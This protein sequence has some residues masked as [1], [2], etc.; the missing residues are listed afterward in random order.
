[1]AFFLVPL[2]FSMN[3]E[4][5]I[6]DLNVITDPECNKLLNVITFGLKCNKLVSVITVPVPWP[7]PCRGVEACVA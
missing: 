7:G 3:S 2:A 6:E 5:S 4:D 1:M